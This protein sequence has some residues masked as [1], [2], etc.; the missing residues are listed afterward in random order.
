MLWKIYNDDQDMVPDLRS[1]D[2]SFVSE[3]VHKNMNTHMRVCT[4]ALR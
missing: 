2:Y 3:A 1:L 4:H